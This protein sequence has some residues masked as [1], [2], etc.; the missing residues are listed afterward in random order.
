MTAVVATS[1]QAALAEVT[2]KAIFDEIWRRCREIGAEGHPVLGV[3]P[4][5]A[6]ELETVRSDYRVIATR[7]MDT[8]RQARAE[9]RI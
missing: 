8:V 2:A 4:D 7:V 6:R 5:W 1:R 3:Y 9:G